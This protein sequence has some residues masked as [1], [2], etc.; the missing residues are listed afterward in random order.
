MEKSMCPAKWGTLCP[1]W[2]LLKVAQISSEKC[3]SCGSDPGS[4]GLQVSDKCLGADQHWKH[5]YRTRRGVC[6][7]TSNNNKRTRADFSPEP[8]FAGFTC[9][10]SVAWVAGVFPCTF[11][12]Q[13]S[14]REVAHHM[15]GHCV[16]CKPGKQTV[17]WVK[18]GEVLS[19]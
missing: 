8:P 1:I 7:T 6:C 15:V 10:L 5:V 11:T 12:I 19:N 3:T 4:L 17:K 14:R 18:L 9:V 13:L 16:L 2:S